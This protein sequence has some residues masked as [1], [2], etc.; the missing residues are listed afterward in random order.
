[1]PDEPDPPRKFYKLKEA[2]F[3]RVNPLPGE[4]Q[5]P[6]TSQDVHAILRDNLDRANE[7][8]LNALTA[9]ERRPSRRKRD[10]WTLLLIGN[11]FFGCGLAYFG[12]QS[13]PGIFALGGMIF[14]SGALTWV[15]WFVMDNY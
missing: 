8:G 14:F 1:M 3:E 7:A 11:A 2:E 5:P 6:T 15:M 9:Q 4:P 10:Y 12:L 13:V